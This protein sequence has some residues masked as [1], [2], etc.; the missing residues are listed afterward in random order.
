MIEADTV[1]VEELVPDGVCEVVGVFEYVASTLRVADS[2]GVCDV[3]CVGVVVC[4][5]ETV[6]NV[7]DG[8]FEG[9][10]IDGK[11][12]EVTDDE[13]DAEADVEVE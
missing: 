13:D 7:F 4:V 8:V 10:G 2:E 12:D 1:R 3:V 9:E 5:E 6:P 11:E